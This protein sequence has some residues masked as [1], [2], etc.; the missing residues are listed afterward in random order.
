MFTVLL[1]DKG[2]APSLSFE[3]TDLEDLSFLYIL[4]LT[5][6][7][8]QLLK[9]EQSLNVN[10]QMFPE[11]LQSLFEYCISGQYGSS[12]DITNGKLGEFSIHQ[13]NGFKTIH[14]LNMKFRE[15]DDTETKK[16]LATRLFLSKQE[17]E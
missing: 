14:H 7:N 6:E 1:S 5:G 11:Y 9:K 4:R 10:F 3:I 13:N 15:A 16:Y 17:N 2:G 12:F 8:F